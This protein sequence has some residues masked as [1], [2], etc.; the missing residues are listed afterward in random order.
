MRIRSIKPE[1]W[2]SPDIA[3]LSDSD[4]LLFIGLWSYV[5]DRGRGRDDVALIVAA[6]YPHDMVANPRDTVAKVRDG[7]ARLSEANLILRYTVASRTYFLV[8]GWGK[9]QRVDKPKASRIPEPTEEENGTF[10]Q[11]DAI[12]ETVATI[13]DDVATP[14][15]TL[16]PGTGEQGNRG[17]GEQGNSDAIGD[18]DLRAVEDPRPDVDAVCDAM[19]ASVQR[20]TGRTPRVTA[21]WRTQAR[22]MIDRDGR[23]VEE[24][25]RVIDW[26][27]GNDFWRAN[28]LSLPKLRQKFDTLRLQSQRPQGR[29]QGGQV[30]YDLAAEFAKEGL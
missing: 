10:P 7:L 3:A 11:N 23:T 9:H 28:V 26:A 19:A 25:A 29:P 15:D 12:R 6:L 30:F 16:A 13:R 22:L 5:D 18:A 1:F 17:T 27:E 2:S 14:R 20:R 21:A 4:R 24:I 8:T